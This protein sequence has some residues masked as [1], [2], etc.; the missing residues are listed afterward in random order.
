LLVDDASD[1]E[2]YGAAVTELLGDEER[3]FEMG[4]NAQE[5]VRDEFLGA[6]SLIQYVDL[7]EKLLD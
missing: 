7:F 3:A 5:R 6:R 4:R 2:A 1:L